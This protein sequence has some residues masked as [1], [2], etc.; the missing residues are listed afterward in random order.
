MD[1]APD[2]TRNGI[3]AAITSIHSSITFT[4]SPLIGGMIID[5]TGGDY[6]S[7]WI[8]YAVS[9]LM[10][11]FLMS[12]ARHAEK[13]NDPLYDIANRKVKDEEA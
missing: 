7:I 13:R 4:L 1:S 6:S 10:G 8:I 12:Q 9:S 5:S 11:I 2:N 3:F